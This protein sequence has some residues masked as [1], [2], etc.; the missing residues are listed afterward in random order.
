M[1]SIT[2]KKPVPCGEI[3]FVF[4]KNGKL[5]IYPENIDGWA[6]DSSMIRAFQDIINWTENK[7][8][9]IEEMKKLGV[10][11]KNNRC[12]KAADDKCFSCADALASAILEYLR[13][14]KHIN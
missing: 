11:L 5:L 7:L 10:L 6:C 12:K 3:N 1:E 9:N 4:R 13:E 8:D 14:I 2:I